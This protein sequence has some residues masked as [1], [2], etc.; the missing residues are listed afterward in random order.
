ME[1]LLA[2]AIL[3]ADIWAIVKTI[4]SPVTGGTK[5][6]WVLLIFLLPVLGL[7]LWVFLGPRSVRG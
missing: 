3:V 4:Q 5:A 2:V 7:I 1:F 6:V